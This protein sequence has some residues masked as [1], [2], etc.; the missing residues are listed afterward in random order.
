M[1]CP[2][3]QL[4]FTL[5]SKGH[6]FR[7]SIN[8]K[9]CVIS[10]QLCVKYYRGKAINISYYISS[11]LSEIF[12]ILWRIQ[13]A[14]STNVHRSLCKVPA[15]LVRLL[16]N[17]D[18]HFRKYSNMKFRISPSSGSWVVPS[19]RTDV[20]KRIVAFRSFANAPKMYL[21]L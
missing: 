17:L 15:I 20:T 9:I 2:A 12:I 10:L 4:F 18:F 19:G 6:D 1:A 8:H 5:S 21:T 3:V 7:K 14:N 13:Q 11:I 16:C